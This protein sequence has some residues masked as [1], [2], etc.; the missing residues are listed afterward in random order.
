M[1][2]PIIP[3]PRA[4]ESTIKALIDSGIIEVREDG[5]HVAEK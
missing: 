5:L 1:G 3:I 4:N 2:K